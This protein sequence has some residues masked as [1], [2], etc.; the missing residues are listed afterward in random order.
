[1]PLTLEIISNLILRLHKTMITLETQLDRQAK[2]LQRSKANK[3]NSE[4]EIAL[5]QN[6][7]SRDA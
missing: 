6:R 7:F 4:I 2:E 1:M 3:N 5:S